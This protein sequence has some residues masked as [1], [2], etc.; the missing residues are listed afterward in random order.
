[1][2]QNY[3]YGIGG[4]PKPEKK[5]AAAQ[6]HVRCMLDGYTGEWAYIDGYDLSGHRFEVKRGKVG[7]VDPNVWEVIF[8]GNDGDMEHPKL[9][10]KKLKFS[11]WERFVFYAA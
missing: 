7:L 2:H 9:V 3:G 8:V 10:V 1:M 11:S 5:R 4:E 6:K